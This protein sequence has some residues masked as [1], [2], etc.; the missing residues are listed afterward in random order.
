MF[1]QRQLS[2][3]RGVALSL[4]M[5]TSLGLTAMAQ[6]ATIEGIVT[7]RSGPSM[8]VKTADSPKL[9]VL[10]SDTTKATEK[11]GFLGLGKRDLGIAELV[12]G[13]TV[14]VEGAYNP[15]HQ[16]MAKKIT[17]SRNSYRVAKQIEA[18][19]DPTNE[20]MAEAQDHLKSDRKDIDQTQQDI[21]K[22]SQDIDAT[23]Q[24]LAAT[25]DATA[26]N[27]K[28]LGRANQR[29]GALDQF[30]TKGSITVNFANGKS[31]VTKKDKDQ[32]TDFVKAAAD[33]PGYMIEV[34]GYASTVGSAALNQK[35][36]AERA[37]AVLA[38]IQQT[39][40]VPMT[41]ILAPAAMGT[42]NQVATEHTR[43]AQAQNRRVVVTIV[44]N[45]GITG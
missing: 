34:Q 18:G 21:A 22:N 31:T 4:A 37:D 23:K 2:T 36:S 19:L 20:Q 45:K 33:T 6:E 35:L 15:D 43:N 17:F 10:L 38:I 13:L 11:G 39:G 32:L 41:R 40:V 29:F 24:G 12:P 16:L 25:N 9:T 30:E 5:F 44:V 27:A 14:K 42:S 7:G 28:G 26:T 3:T 1:I 8:S